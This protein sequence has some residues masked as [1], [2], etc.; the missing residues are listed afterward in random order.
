MK[1]V[2]LEKVFFEYF[3]F[4]IPVN[5]TSSHLSLPMRC[6]VGLSSKE[7]IIIISALNSVLSAIL[8]QM[9]KASV[10]GL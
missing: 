8:V 1:S 10:D 7:G 3:D 9:G 4:P 2:V 6:A 5:S